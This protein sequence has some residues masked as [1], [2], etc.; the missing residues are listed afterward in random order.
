M[1]FDRI[2]YMFAFNMRNGKNYHV[3]LKLVAAG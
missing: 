2:Q 1:C 3:D